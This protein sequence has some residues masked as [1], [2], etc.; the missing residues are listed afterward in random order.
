MHL[1]NLM[2]PHERAPLPRL[3]EAQREKLGAC[4]DKLG[5]TKRSPTHT[6]VV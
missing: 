3:N 1:M 2:P 4:V 5:W 6:A